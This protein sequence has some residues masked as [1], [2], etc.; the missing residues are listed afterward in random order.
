[1][2]VACARVCVHSIISR[3]GTRFVTNLE[4][5]LYKF[6]ENIS[7]SWSATAP[8]LF[9]NKKNRRRRRYR[10]TVERI[11]RQ[12]FVAARYVYVRAAV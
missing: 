12:T 9:Y 3:A 2:T 7:S 1:M 8:V 11:S 6:D 4:L 10:Q 5:V